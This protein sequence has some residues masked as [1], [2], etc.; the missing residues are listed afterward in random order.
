MTRRPPA[1]D[2]TGAGSTE[3]HDIGIA[4]DRDDLLA[5]NREG[6]RLG[7]TALQRR[8]LGIVHD[9]VRGCFPSLVS[10]AG[11]NS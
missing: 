6:R 4:S 8:H 1:S 9:Q 10:A 11:P 7:P 5:A 3:T 2:D